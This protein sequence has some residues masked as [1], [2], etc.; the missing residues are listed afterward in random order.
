MNV[1][2]WIDRQLHVRTSLH[3]CHINIMGR[4]YKIEKI[5]GPDKNNYLSVTYSGDQ[6][7]Q[8]HLDDLGAMTNPTM[9]MF[10][11]SDPDGYSGVLVIP[12]DQGGS[13]DSA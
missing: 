1:L 13:N 12:G 6:R 8:I 11:C 4:S 9:F 10:D 5:E 7:V 3:T 2:Y